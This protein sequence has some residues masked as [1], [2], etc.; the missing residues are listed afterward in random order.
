MPDAPLALRPGPPR[1]AHHLAHSV[2][3]MPSR[4]H[5]APAL[6]LTLS[7]DALRRGPQRPVGDAWRPEF[8][9]VGGDWAYLAHGPLPLG[10]CP[11]S[12]ASG[13]GA[14]PVWSRTACLFSGR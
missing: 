5:G 9:T 10:L 3:K 14:H 8:G 11:W 12:A 6:C 7:R 2:Y 1:W 4:I 13:D